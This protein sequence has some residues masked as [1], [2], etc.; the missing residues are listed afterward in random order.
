[1]NKVMLMGR[2]TRDPEI[3]YTAGENQ[4]AVAKWSVA[5]ERRFGKEKETDFFDCTAFGKTAE[6]VEKYWKKGMKMLLIGRLEQR[7]WTDKEG[8]PKSS[9]GV[10]VEDI[11]FCERKDANPETTKTVE[12]DDGL[13]FTF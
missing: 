7:R 10:T 8:K 11:E 4:T 1:M 12:A 2:L 6:H 13:P 5:V 9:V 3:K